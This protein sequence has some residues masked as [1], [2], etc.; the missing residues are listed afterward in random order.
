MTAIHDVLTGMEALGGRDLILSLHKHVENN[1]TP[2]DERKE[3]VAS[4]REICRDAEPKKITV[5][6]RQAVANRQSDD[7][8]A[9]IQFVS[10][11]GAPN[12][13]LAPS[14]ALLLAAKVAPRLI[15]SPNVFGMWL[16]ST[17]SV[18]VAGGLWS[19]NS[20]IANGEFS[21]D[22]AALIRI[23][24]DLPVVA[25]VSYADHDQEYL[26]S[27]ALDRIMKAASGQ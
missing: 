20:A 27:V 25:D 18:D 5:Y 26:D 1:L 9:A 4:V 8:S 24:P 19:I 12:L 14:T 7:L 23:S 3:L 21:Q 10:D 13:K 17:P 16:V 15:A 11:V 2:A 6:L 22:L